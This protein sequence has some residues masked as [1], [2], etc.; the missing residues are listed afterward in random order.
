MIRSEICFDRAP[1]THYERFTF[2]SGSPVVCVTAGIHGDEQTGVY[3]AHQLIRRLEK[4]TVHGTV[5]IYPV[6]NP[7]AFRHRARVSPFDGLDLNRTFG[8]PAQGTH[9]AQLAHSLWQETADADFLLDLHCC[10]QYG[11]TYVMS[12]HADYDHQYEL[13]RALG[14]K[15]VMRSSGAAGQLFVETNHDGRRSILIE[16]RGGQPAGAIDLE[17]GSQVLEAA[18]RFLNYCQV[19][20][21]PTAPPEEVCFHDK[22]QRVMAP[23]N[24]LLLPVLTPGTD[25]KQGDVVLTLD[26]IAMTAPCDGTILAVAKPQYLFQGERAFTIAPF[27]TA[28]G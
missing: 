21:V 16:I 25:C 12:M 7:T 2:G 11:S 6:C 27:W 23:R 24:G 17:A 22:I 10:G 8:Q 26:G 13:A 5:R 3:V 18:L 14:L 15:Q 19:I 4:E 20:Q 28:K 9:T 1:I